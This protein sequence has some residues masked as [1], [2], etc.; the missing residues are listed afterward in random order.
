MTIYE[1]LKNSISNAPS[2]EAAYDYEEVIDSELY[3]GRITEEEASE[4]YD[5]MEGVAMHF[6]DL[7]I[8]TPRSFR[9]KEVIEEWKAKH[10]NKLTFKEWLKESYNLDIITFSEK[11]EGYKRRIRSSY[12]YY[13]HPED[14]EEMELKDSKINDII[15]ET[16]E[17]YVIYS[18]K[19]KR[20][21]KAYKSKKEAEERLK[22]IEMFK[23][24]K[25]DSK[26]Y[27]IIN[28]KGHYE[29]HENG[30]F[31]SSADSYSEAK[32]DLEQLIKEDEKRMVSKP[33]KNHYEIEFVIDDDVYTTDVW[34]Y[35][36]DEAI[37]QVKHEWK[38]SKIL[39][40]P[41]IKKIE[42]SL[43]DKRFVCKSYFDIKSRGL[44][45][46][47][48][49]NDLG[50]VKDWVLEKSNNGYYTRVIDK[51]TG[52]VWDFGMIDDPFELDKIKPYYEE[53]EIDEEDLE[54]IT[55]EEVHFW[56]VEWY[57]KNGHKFQG[58]F[59]SKEDAEEFMKEISDDNHFEVKL[60]EEDRF[61]GDSISVL[62]KEELANKLKKILSN[63]LV[64]EGFE[65]S[66]VN[67]WVNVHIRNFTNE[68]GDKGVEVELANEFI[69]YYDLPE[70]VMK[71][72]DDAVA[73]AYF[74]PY[75]A[76]IWQAYLFDTKVEDSIKDESISEQEY[77]NLVNRAKH[78]EILN[79]YEVSP[80]GAE[81]FQ[82]VYNYLS[83]PKDEEWIVA[84]EVLKDDK[85]MEKLYNTLK[86]AVISEL[87][88]NPYVFDTEHD[89]H[90]GEHKGTEEVMKMFDIKINFVEDEDDSNRL[91]D[92]VTRCQEILK[93]GLVKEGY[94]S[95][96]DADIKIEHQKAGE[97]DQI[98]L[99]GNPEW[100]GTDLE[101]ETVEDVDKEIK[102]L[103]PNSQ[104]T[105]YEDTTGGYWTLKE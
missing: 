3:K 81:M 75:S 45:D 90:Y 30:K 82:D 105:W 74:E 60:R 92:L 78:G 37:K 83:L 13:L 18:E 55:P 46:Q 95:E 4:L 19:G 68:Y 56:V 25:K 7:Y 14:Y 104:F 69:D 23:H 80:A 1:K 36:Q 84:P 50:K 59:D 41:N 70:D 20:L 9:D 54:I 8:T 42:D 16:K 11:P 26:K 85:S 65:Q 94:K 49:F 100:T 22:E 91:M 88:E 87:K 24:M 98:L 33:R 10:P 39:A 27:E 67:E 76:T 73:P 5:L 38:G 52:E 28:N 6:E 97:Y 79:M 72:L 35:S 99:K 32:K 96:E 93:R 103:Y 15:K 2:A 51:E 40:F 61:I 58:E 101:K 63:Y 12:D 77:E 21:S 102:M 48:E 66:D 34:A 86:E 57:N 89:K 44:E 64:K 47:E 17:G 53:E 31:L 29:I 71:A 43:T 62:N